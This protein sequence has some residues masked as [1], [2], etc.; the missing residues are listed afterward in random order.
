MTLKDKIKIK[1]ADDYDLVEDIILDL[2]FYNLREYGS[3][4]RF[5]YD[6]WSNSS[7]LRIYK[8]S[9]SYKNYKYPDKNGDI[10]SLVQYKKS[11]SFEKAMEYLAYKC[12]YSEI[13]VEESIKVVKPFGSFFKKI[14]NIKN[15]F[16]IEPLDDSLVDKYRKSYFELLLLEGITIEA[17]DFFNV[18]YDLASGRIA[19]PIYK[20]EGLVGI[21]GRIN[22][23]NFDEGV[24]KYLPIIPYPKS[25]V[26]FG[27]IENKKYIK[28]NRV[29][30]VE[31]EKS[32]IKAF[33][34]GYRNVVALGGNSISEFQKLAIHSMYPKEIVVA[35]DEGL[36]LSHIKNQAESMKT[37]NILFKKANIGYIDPFGLD[38]KSCIFD[39]TEEQCKNKIKEVIWI[40]N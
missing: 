31:S 4:W 37:L 22:Q 28:N 18:R 39:M 5:G 13:E 23:R 19:I 36:E 32:V 30:V 21:L 15:D 26:L 9:L 29:Y 27:E 17:Q 20:K 3:Y 16:H 1:L 34:M 12:G 35:L 25:K 24:A 6:E 14:K 33:S 7:A 8:G 38:R 10:I 2:G 11:C 40:G